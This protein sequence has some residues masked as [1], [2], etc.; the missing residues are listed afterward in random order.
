[1]FEELGADFT[2]LAFGAD[3]PAIAAFTAAAASLRMPLRVVR[4]SLAAGREA[5]EARLVLVRADRYVAWASNEAPLD[6]ASV[7]AKLIGR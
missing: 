4:D 6:A 2:L 1:M 7:I 5:Y 3:E